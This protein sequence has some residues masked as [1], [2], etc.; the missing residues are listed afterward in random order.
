MG[1]LASAF[2]WASGLKG[3]ATGPG[4]LLERSIELS[5]G[6]LKD[7]F[8]PFEACMAFSTKTKGHHPSQGNVQ[9]YSVRIPVSGPLQKSW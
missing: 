6:S 4:Q 7:T 1:Q 2:T 5:Q 8:C 9:V 3:K